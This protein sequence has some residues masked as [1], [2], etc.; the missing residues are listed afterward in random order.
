M[1]QTTKEKSWQTFEDTSWSPGSFDWVVKE[2]GPSSIDAEDNAGA[3]EDWVVST[4]ETAS[5][6]R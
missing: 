1:F 6:T 5:E 4:G 2:N 3:P